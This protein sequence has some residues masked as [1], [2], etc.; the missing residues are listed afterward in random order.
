M[1]LPAKGDSPPNTRYK[2]RGAMRHVMGQNTKSRV[3]VAGKEGEV[4]MGMG[5]IGSGEHRCRQR[6]CG[7]ASS[8]S[9]SSWVLMKASRKLKAASQIGHTKRP[10][11]AG[12]FSPGTATMSVR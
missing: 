2:S 11:I 6:R 5:W 12:A 3:A 10:L 7:L 1:S 9:S 4:V 8:S